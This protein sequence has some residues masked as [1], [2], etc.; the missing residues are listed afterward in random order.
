MG[1]VIIQRDSGY[2]DRIRKY[3]VIL[4]G[5]E[6][7]KIGNGETKEFDAPLGDN[8]V[9]LKI[10]WC[11]SNKLGFESHKDS[12]ERYECGS[13]LRGIK[14]LFAII[15]VFMPHKWIWLKNA[16]NKAI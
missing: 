12:V 15:Y 13:S 14:L 5:K 1:K 11:R 9:F 8:E 4:N 6:V 10:D 2:A 3:K 16:S 7:G